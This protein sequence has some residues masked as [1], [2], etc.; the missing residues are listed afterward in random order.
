MVQTDF[1]AAALAE[2]LRKVFDLSGR[3]LTRPLAGSILSLD[4]EDRDAE[5]IEVLHQC[6]RIAGTLAI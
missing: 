1:R 3:G 4:F 6:R 2:L 5:R